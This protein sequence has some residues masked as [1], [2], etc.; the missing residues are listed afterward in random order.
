MPDTTLPI[1]WRKTPEALRDLKKAKNPELLAKYF[2]RSVSGMPNFSGAMFNSLGHPTSTPD[3]INESDIAAVGLLSTPLKN[4]P[5][6]QLL[7]VPCETV[8]K[9][10]SSSISAISTETELAN[11]GKKLIDELESS[12]EVLWPVDY[13]GHTRISKLLARKR[14][15]SAPITDSVIV[16]ELGLKSTWKYKDFCADL[17][18]YLQAEVAGKSNHTQLLSIRNDAVS[19]LEKKNQIEAAHDLNQISAIRVFDI[20]VWS[21]ARNQ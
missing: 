10:F 18:E 6:L 20:L 14:P 13:L 1:S 5:I 19:I 9:D 21:S 8:S 16:R 2:L 4:Q 11:G 17:Q 3:Q 15:K 7:G 12:F